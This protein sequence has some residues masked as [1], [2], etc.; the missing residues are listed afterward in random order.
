MRLLV[1]LVSLGVACTPKEPRTGGP[2]SS[3]TS[4]V[5]AF[6]PLCDSRP[7]RLRAYDAIEVGQRFTLDVVKDENGEWRPAE[8]LDMPMHHA[9]L[10]EW[11]A[12]KELLAP[13]STERVTV[14][15]RGHGRVSLVHEPETRAWFAT[16]AADI[17]TVCGTRER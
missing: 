14:I 2:A 11:R 7:A 8:S 5:G 12:G 10:L 16:Y 3:G 6:N 4:I 9:S 1:L 13:Y 17:E 15:A